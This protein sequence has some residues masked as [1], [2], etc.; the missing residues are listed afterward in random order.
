MSLEGTPLWEFRGGGVDNDYGRAVAM[1]VDENH[2]FVAGFFY[3]IPA[4]FGSTVLHKTSGSFVGFL[5]KVGLVALRLTILNADLVFTSRYNEATHAYKH[6]LPVSK[7]VLR[8][9]VVP[10]GRQCSFGCDNPQRLS[11]GQGG[12]ASARCLCRT[13]SSIFLRSVITGVQRFKCIVAMED[14]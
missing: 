3:S 6:Q 4:T 5:L 13:R 9:P 8:P 12:V 11:N 7:K 1:S 14:L 2:V 10:V